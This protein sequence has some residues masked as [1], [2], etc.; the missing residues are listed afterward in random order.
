[1]I[2]RVL[3]AVEKS[4]FF[5][6]IKMLGIVEK[7]AP[8]EIK[9][10]MTI[11]QAFLIDYL[12]NTIKP[13]AMRSP[14][15]PPIFLYYYQNKGKHTAIIRFILNYFQAIRKKRESDWDNPSESIICNSIGIGALIRVMHFIFVKMFSDKFEGD[16]HRIQGID[17]ASLMDQLS[18]LEEVDF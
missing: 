8:P 5:R 16:P 1:E 15:Y 12:V 14:T 9:A 18:G 13:D 10:K 4:P 17:V 3:N 7:E 2:I 6:R 11:S